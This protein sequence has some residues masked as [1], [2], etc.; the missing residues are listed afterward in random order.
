MHDHHV[1]FLQ[2]GSRLVESREDAW[3]Q[4]W[5]EAAEGVQ[6]GFA[7]VAQKVLTAPG[8]RGLQRH[9]PVAAVKQVAQHATQEMRVAMV[10]AGGEGV[11]E[12]D[13]FHGTVASIVTGPIGCGRES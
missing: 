9:D 10:P 3:L 2:G 5:I 13:E 7:M 4:L 11:G 8:A 1:S 12:I 6:T